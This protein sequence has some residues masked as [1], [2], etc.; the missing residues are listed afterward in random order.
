[1]KT[2][3]LWN[4]PAI[5]GA[6]VDNPQPVANPSI[7]ISKSFRTVGDSSLGTRLVRMIML[8]LACLC[9]FSGDPAL[10]QKR[11]PSKAAGG[12]SPSIP[13]RYRRRGPVIWMG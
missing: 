2:A 1:M 12:L 7:G 4:L 5:T 9:F 8:S 10:A 13:R 6:A 11:A 3:R